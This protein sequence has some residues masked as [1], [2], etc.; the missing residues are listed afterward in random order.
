VASEFGDR[1]PGWFADEYRRLNLPLMKYYAILTTNTRMIVMA[2]CVLLDVPWLYFLVE[3]AGINAVMLFVT[4]RQER[5]S[6]ALLRGIE[7]RKV[8]A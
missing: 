1:I 5:L 7:S 6:A 2:A 3:V 4:A 8:A